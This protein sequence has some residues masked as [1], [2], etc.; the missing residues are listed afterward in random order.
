MTP[1]CQEHL[2]KRIIP[3]QGAHLLKR[4]L[5][6]RCVHLLRSLPPGRAIHHGRHLAEGNGPL[7]VRECS[8]RRAVPPRRASL[9]VLPPDDRFPRQVEAAGPMRWGGTPS[10]PRCGTA[11]A[12]RRLLIHDFS[13]QG[14]RVVSTSRRARF[15]LVDEIYSRE[16]TAAPTVLAIPPRVGSSL[17]ETSAAPEYSCRNQLSG[18]TDS[19]SNIYADLQPRMIISPIVGFLF[20]LDSSA[21]ITCSRIFFTIL[22]FRLTLMTLRT[23]PRKLYLIWWRQAPLR[24]WTNLVEELFALFLRYVQGGSIM[25]LPPSHGK[26]LGNHKIRPIKVDDIQHSF[27]NQCQSSLLQELNSSIRKGF[28]NIAK[29]THRLH[30]GSG[31]RNFIFSFFFFLFGAVSQAKGTKTLKVTTSSTITQMES[32]KM[33]Y[34]IG[35]MIIALQYT[36]SS[37][38]TKIESE[39]YLSFHQETSSY[40][41][42][43]FSKHLMGLCLVTAGTENHL[44]SRYSQDSFRNVKNGFWKLL[45]TNGISI[46][47]FILEFFSELFLYM[48]LNWMMDSFRTTMRPSQTKKWNPFQITISSGCGGIYMSLLD[49]IEHGINDFCS[50]MAVCQNSFFVHFSEHT[51][52]TLKIWCE[53]NTVKLFSGLS[54]I[55]YKPFIHLFFY[56]HNHCKPSLAQLFKLDPSQQ[57]RALSHCLLFPILWRL[58]IQ[59]DF[60]V[61]GAGWEH[62]RHYFIDKEKYIVALQKKIAQL[63]AVDMQKVPGSFLC[64]SNHSPKVIQQSVDAQSLCILTVTVPKNLYMQIF[65]HVF[66]QYWKK[67]HEEKISHNMADCWQCLYPIMSLIAPLT[68]DTSQHWIIKGYILEIYGKGLLWCSNLIHLLIFFKESAYPSQILV[69][70]FQPSNQNDSTFQIFETRIRIRSPFNPVN[71][72]KINLIIHTLWYAFCWKNLRVLIFMIFSG[73]IYMYHSF[74]N[75]HTRIFFDTISHVTYLYFI[76]VVSVVRHM[77]CS[78]GGDIIEVKQLC[79][80]KHVLTASRV[81]GTTRI[82]HCTAE[83]DIINSQHLVV[84]TSRKRSHF[85]IKEA[86]LSA[87]FWDLIIPADQHSLLHISCRG[88]TSTSY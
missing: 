55:F 76:Y 56:P 88:N 47:P 82:F 83:H 37:N 14:G 74:Q 32:H 10:L 11:T 19:T 67:K 39:I 41:S 25:D 87:H 45:L 29:C 40:F 72:L 9:A 26:T 81:H 33:S 77:H 6:W 58:A 71:Y 24:S 42:A 13:S 86:L 69:N 48:K 66:L 70:F 2:P 61:S 18:R 21:K 17:L 27:V 3:R 63:P 46:P 4:L 31:G 8:P 44:A 7:A 5:P 85:S 84:L 73:F 49:K 15:H 35:G 64:Y 52:R 23:R 60:G 38:K 59:L 43:R 12:D 51:C 80:K 57:L 20:S 28:M 30:L 36:I 54:L 68:P 78:S 53:I 50:L 79:C 22:H 65:E 16:G 75:V 34:N 1:H 62:L